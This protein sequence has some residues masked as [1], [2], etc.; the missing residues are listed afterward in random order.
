MRIRFWGIFCI[1]ATS[2]ETAEHSFLKILKIGKVE[3]C[4]GSNGRAAID[5]FSSLEYPWLLI[6]DN[7]DDPTHPV[8]DY[9][10]SGERGCILVTTRDP[11]K[12][13]QGTVGPKFYHFGQLETHEAND[14]LLKAAC[15]PMPWGLSTIKYANS[16][17]SILGFLPLALVQAGKAIINHVCSLANYIEHYQKSW[18]WIRHARRNSRHET[19]YWNVY[20]S[21]EI[22]LQSLEKSHKEE[23]LDALALLKMFSFLHCQNI[24]IDFLIAVAMNPAIER[25]HEEQTKNEEKEMKALNRQK[26]WSGRLRDMVH[27]IAEYANRDRGPATL[28]AVLRDG[29]PPSPFDELRLRHALGILSRM[30]LITHHESADVYS[31][32]LLVHTWVRE[33]PERN[34]EQAIWCQVA[35]TAL[36]QAIIL[37]PHGDSEKEANMRRNLLPHINHVRKFQA[38]INSKISDN[39]KKRQIT[40]PRALETRFGPR[41]AL[42]SAKFSRVYMECGLW[43]EAEELQVEVK[44]FICS[45][46]S[47]EDPKTIGIK[48]FL[49]ITYLNQTRANEAAQLQDQVYQA[50]LKSL[51]PNHPKTLKAMDTLA[52]TKCFG[53]RFRESLQLHEQATEGM[54]KSSLT[55]PEDLYI[56]IGNLGKILGRYYRYEEAK[57]LHTEALDGLTRVLGPTHLKTITAME[58]LA[59]SYLECGEKWLEKAQA[60]MLDVHSQRE[61]RLGPEQPFTLLAIC[62][63]ARVKIAMGQAVEA[64]NLFRGAIPIAER[65]LGGNHSGTLFGKLHFAQALVKQERYD[66]AEKVFVKVVEKKRYASSARKDGDHPDRIIALWYM[67]QCY[68]LQGKVDDALAK[69]DELEGAIA[70]IGGEGLGKLHPL[71][72]KVASKRVE[73]K[74][75]ERNK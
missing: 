62:N 57:D 8:E 67:I 48:M 71:A 32:H 36:A 33:R 17:S 26:T 60:L 72:E 14:L 59:M 25:M 63:L 41:Q 21:Y 37:P 42:E 2:P 29:G 47:N 40:W 11:I 68:E 56:A 20:S 35:A 16:I 52:L 23:A 39:R 46:L 22:N 9:F 43:R 13:V 58:D 50:C 53:G 4:E 15:E 73:L 54:R 69:I 55:K 12:K 61:S 10:P 6:I 3:P 70:T 28:P 7:A 75:R 65:T 64:E 31:M 45:K 44:D 74:L 49:S 30:S 27:M 5:W 1:N 18:Q 24:H 38:D 34:G 51:G 66:E 19:T